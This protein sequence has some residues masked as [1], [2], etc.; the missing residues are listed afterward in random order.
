MRK[1][2]PGVGGPPWR[3]RSKALAVVAGVIIGVWPASVKADLLESQTFGPT[4]PTTDLGLAPFDP[5]LGTLEEVSLRATVVTTIPAGDTIDLYT[6]VGPESP[7]FL[8]E[9]CPA[10]PHSCSL[11]IAYDYPSLTDPSVLAAFSAP[12]T[13]EF[14]VTPMGVALDPST[15]GVL[16]YYYTPPIPE[17]SAVVL[18]ST[19]LVAVGFLA[20]KRIAAGH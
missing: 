6:I 20:R 1:P 8:N 9:S 17:P 5:S 4:G 10:G 14:Y 12:F 16:E 3:Y 15:S 13:D 19:L 18:M 11:T 7:S 2:S